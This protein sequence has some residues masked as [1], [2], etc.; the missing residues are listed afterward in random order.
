[1][2]DKKLIKIINDIRYFEN[3]EWIDLSEIPKIKSLYNWLDA[4]GCVCKFKCENVVGS[5]TIK[6]T[7]RINNSTKFLVDYNGFEIEFAPKN[8][9]TLKFGNLLKGVKRGEFLYKIG[10]K[11]HNEFRDCIVI[12]RKIEKKKRSGN[13]TYYSTVKL[14]KVKCIKCC[15]EGGAYYRLGEKYN[16]YWILE[17]N[18]N[19]T[20]CPCCCKFKQIVVPNINSIVSNKSTLWMIDY[21]DGE[22]Y[23][24]KY[25][26]AKKWTYNSEQKVDV[27]CPCCGYKKGN[28]I[29]SNLYYNNGVY[30]PNCS[31]GISYPNKILYNICQQLISKNILNNYVY[32]FCPEW[33]VFDYKNKKRKGI[34]DGKLEINNKKIIIEMD[35]GFHYYDNKMTNGLTTL[36]QN[37]VDNEKDDLAVQH[38]YDVIRIDC[39]YDKIYDKFNYIKQNILNSKLKLYL[40]LSLIDWEKCYSE[41]NKSFKTE[42]IK[43]YNNNIDISIISG[44]FN[45][46]KPTIIKYL[47]EATNVGICNF[48]YLNEASPI[49]IIENGYAFRSIK[50]LSDKSNELFG[51][52]LDYIKLKNSIKKH[53]EYNGFTFIHI[54]KEMFNTTSINKF[55]KN[56][57]N[58]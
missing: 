38:G 57:I 40:D 21:F 32:E 1:M 25:N 7:Y 17:S 58:L 24:E 14:Y 23:D 43:M 51:I 50:L 55:G 4:D 49:K 45:I 46:G 39:N 37:I 16:D 6:N 18:I 41:S 56:F 54:T 11:I 44:I 52:N 15:Y 42:I 26:I 2:S 33:C 20:S 36:E 3:D 13:N 30:C 29:I 28:M 9:T 34:Y 8:F 47:R 31:D 53:Q 10:Q 48:K 12:D 22:T 35:G 19:K 5:L 27:S